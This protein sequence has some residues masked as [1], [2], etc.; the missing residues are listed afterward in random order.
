MFEIFR[1]TVSSCF[2][3]SFDVPFENGIFR[4]NQAFYL[5]DEDS[6]SCDDSRVN[7]ISSLVSIRMKEA[8]LNNYYI[9]KAL[10]E[11]SDTD[12]VV[13][14]L[15]KVVGNILIANFPNMETLTIKKETIPNVRSLTVY[16]NPKLKTFDCKSDCC[17]VTLQLFFLGITLNR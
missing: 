17:W 15:E 1:Y 7:S 2:F 3:S 13:E 4:S 16:N 6:I 12:V 8:I 9:D 14:K 11:T 5:L 10:K